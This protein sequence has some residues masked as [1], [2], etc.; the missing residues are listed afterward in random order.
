M[1]CKQTIWRVNRHYRMYREFIECK[2]NFKL[3]LQGHQERGLH[4]VY[5]SQASLHGNLLLVM[6]SYHWYMR[7]RAR[8]EGTTL[9]NPTLLAFKL[10]GYPVSCYY[11]KL[12]GSFMI[13][14]FISFVNLLST[15]LLESL[16]HSSWWLME[17]YKGTV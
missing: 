15:Q 16:L 5:C 17:V 10:H 4:S 7:K 9:V 13:H 8:A 6:I 3:K 2:K 12:R 1:A 14:I 11:L